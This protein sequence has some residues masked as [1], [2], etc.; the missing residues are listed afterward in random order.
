MKRRA[1]IHLNLLSL[2]C[3]SGPDEYTCTLEPQMWNLV[4]KE[5]YIW[6][7]RYR[8]GSGQHMCGNSLRLDT[9]TQGVNVAKK[10]G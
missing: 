3:P 5:I 8:F 7:G 9:V 6:A 2:G 1:G 10:Q 4:E